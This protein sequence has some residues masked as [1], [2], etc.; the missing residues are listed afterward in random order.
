[1]RVCFT[2]VSRDRERVRD[3][4]GNG[5]RAKGSTNNKPQSPF[6]STVSKIERISLCPCL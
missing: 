3:V 6:P 5:K 4:W 2:R 1:M